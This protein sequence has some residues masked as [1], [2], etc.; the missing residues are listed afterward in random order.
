MLFQSLAHLKQNFWRLAGSQ[1]LG[2]NQI[3][4]N[5]NREKQ[6]SSLFAEDLLKISA[7][8]TWCQKVFPFLI[9]LPTFWSYSL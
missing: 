8:D 1:E 4:T 9:H 3:N 2:F 6:C 7:D 5:R